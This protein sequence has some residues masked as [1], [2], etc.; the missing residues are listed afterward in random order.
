MSKDWVD[1]SAQ[2]GL[3]D[4]MKVIVTDPTADTKLT[5]IIE[6]RMNL[7]MYIDNI[8]VVYL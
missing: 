7:E 3:P 4:G 8:A 2:N 5:K 1:K 6:H